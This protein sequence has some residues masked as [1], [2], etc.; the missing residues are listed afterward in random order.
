[1]LNTILGK[2]ISMEQTFVNE[3]RIPVTLVE[4]G[5]CVVTQVK[6]KD[7]D[8]YW[9]VQLGFGQKKT[10]NV[11]M[12][13]RGHLKSVIKGKFAPAFI[14]EIKLTEE[15]D[16]K[17]G[18]QI[19]V[20]D[21]FSEGDTVTVTGTSK[22]KGFAGV[23]KRWGFAGGPKTH[24]QSD[25]HRA[26][27]SI[28]QGTTPGRV[29]KG[30]KMAGRMGNQRITVKNLKVVSVNT[31]KNR[32]SISGPVPGS[33]GSYLMIRKEKNG[34]RNDLKTKGLES[35]S[36]SEGDQTQSSND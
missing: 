29:H 36:V 27:G 21:I 2:K 9:S 12:P 26:P 33:Y 16:F 1:M 34:R 31:D 17:V 3:V 30:K 7:R 24:G 22:G 32:I 25:R 8:G 18:D 4:A 10:K 14:R 13:V 28:G 5:P 20:S 23:V 6:N 19:K 11:T 35:E 15:P